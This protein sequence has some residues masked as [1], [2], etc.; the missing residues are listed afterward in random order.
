MKALALLVRDERHA[1]RKE[2]QNLVLDSIQTRRDRGFRIEAG[3]AQRLGDPIRAR[4]RALR[5]IP[6]TSAGDDR[7]QPLQEVAA[8]SDQFGLERPTSPRIRSS[9]PTTSSNMWILRSRSSIKFAS[10]VS[11]AHTFTT[12]TSRS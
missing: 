2:Q 12:W 1:E 6:L 9:S 3:F 7:D 11:S 10:T 5:H 4:D 8:G